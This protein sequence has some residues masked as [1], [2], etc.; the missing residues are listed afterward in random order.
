VPYVD[1]GFILA[2]TLKQALENYRARTGRQL[3]KAILMANHGLIVAGDDPSAIRAN[4]DEILQK[5]AAR[6]GDDWQT[7]SIGAVTRI[8]DATGFVRRIGPALRALL[9]E[10]PAE[11]LKVVTCDDSDIALGLIG[12]EAGQAMACA[13]P[14]TPIRSC[15]A[16]ATRCGSI[17]KPMKTRTR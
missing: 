15:T 10:D 5:I 17:R 16:T 3:P 2:Q 8:G 4:T 1:P 11:P 7:R 13:G 9:A 6:L 12:S 14:L